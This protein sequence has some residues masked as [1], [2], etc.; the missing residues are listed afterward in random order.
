MYNEFENR[1]FEGIYYS[2]FVASWCK[3]GGKLNWEFKEWLKQLVINKKKIPDD[4]IR[5]IYNYATNGKLELEMDAELY[6]NA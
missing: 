1:Q 3:S 5:E 4:T 2:R 6:L